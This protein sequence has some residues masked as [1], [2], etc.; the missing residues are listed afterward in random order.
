MSTAGKAVTDLTPLHAPVPP[1]LAK[2]IGYTG[3]ARF[4]SFHWTPAGDETYYS[5]G[6]ISATGNWQTYLAFIRHPAVN[7]HLKGY[8]FGSSDSEAEHSLLLDRLYLALYVAP[9]RDAE[10]F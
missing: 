10:N 9:V 3:D 6:C 1:M 7:P 4:V 5:D 2:A 8:D